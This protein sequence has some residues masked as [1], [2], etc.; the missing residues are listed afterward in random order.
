MKGLI[1]ITYK[2]PCKIIKIDKYTGKI[3]IPTLL[4]MNRS[5]HT[6]GKISRYED[7]HISL[8]G[9]GI[10]EISFNVHKYAD[11]ILC[12]VWDDLIDLKLVYVDGFGCF[13]ISV[14]Y[15]DNTETVKSIH[16][17]SLETELG[18]I[19]LHD[20]HVN[21]EEAADMVLTEYSKDNYDSDGNYIPTVFYDP[22]NE[23][24]SLLH[25]VIASKA[26]HW[27]IGYVTPYITLGED[28][29][30]EESSKFQ[31]TYSVNGESI[32]DFLTGTVSEESNVIFVFNVSRDETTGNIERTINCYSLCDCV[33]QE[34]G[35]ILCNGIGEDTMV[36][37]SKTKLANEISISSNKDN[38]KNCFCVEGGDD[39]ITNYVKAANMNGS[40]YIYQF[41][42]FQ[43][44]DMSEALKTKIQSYQEMMSSKETEEAYY[45]KGEKFQ[46]FLT[47]SYA[48]NISS[49]TDAA[50][51]LNM[52]QNEG[53][54]TSN[55]D[56]TRYDR[57]WYISKITKNGKVIRELEHS[58][59]LINNYD[60]YASG[61]V[62]R[63]LGIYTKLCN[64]YD[65]LGYFKSSM[66]PNADSATEPGDAETQY[67]KI[68]D[69]VDY[70]RTNKSTVAVSSLDDYNDEH[71]LTLTSRVDEYIQVFLDSRFDLSIIKD[72][73]SYNT[74]SHMWTGKI[75]IKQHSD[76]TN[77]YPVDITNAGL[78]TIKVNDD[79]FEYAKQK[80]YKA[81]ASSSMMD[82]DFDVANMGNA[83]MKQYF[84]RYSLNRLSAFS[85]GYDYCI[86]VLAQM[87]DSDVRKSLLS[88]YGQRLHI[89]DV[90]K[91]ERQKDVDN[92]NVMI[93]E[94]LKE[95]KTFIYGGIY[96]NGSRYKI[97]EAHDFKTYLG[98]DE[99]YKEFCS[100]TREDT[101]TNSNYVS[102]GL[103]T[104][105]CIE[106]A[107]ELLEIAN[108]EIRKACVLQRTVSTS[109]NNIFALPEFEKLYDKFSLF[110][111]IRVK[112]EDEIL[113]LR[114]IGIEFSGDSVEKIDVTFS[115]QIESIDGKLS[116]LQSII[117]QAS[118][119][120]TS[121]PSTAL[122]AK[123][124]AGADSEITNMYTNGLNAAKTMLKNNDNNEVTITKSGIVCKRMDDDGN[125]GD[126]QLRITG[127]IMALTDDGWKSVKMAVGE[128]IFYNPFSQKYELKYGIQASVIVGELM[129]SENMFIGNKDR[130][131]KITGDG[132][133][134]SNGVIKSSDYSKDG[135]GNETGSIIDLRDGSFSF[136]NGGLKYRDNDLVMKN[137][138]IQSSNAMKDIHTGEM[139]GNVVINLDT[140]YFMLGDRRLEFNALT[141]R[142]KIKGDITAESITAYDSYKLYSNGSFKEVLYGN[143]NA[144]NNGVWYIDLKLNQYAYIT[145]T[146][147]PNINAEEGR[148]VN[149]I[150]IHTDNIKLEGNAYSQT[151]QIITSDRNLKDNIKPLTDKHIKFFSLLQPVSFT[152]IDGTY[153][154][155]HIGF[156]SQDVENAMYEAGLTDLDFAGFCKD[157]KKTE[158]TDED[159]NKRY[160]TEVDENGDPIYAYYLRYDEFVAL[161][162]FIIQKLYGE[163][164][165]MK[166][167]IQELQQDN[168][169]L[170]ERLSYLENFIINKTA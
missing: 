158:I 102:D 170:N 90:I 72:S 134:I 66:M 64:A 124:G 62:L 125:Y 21:D 129:C 113:K 5:F 93:E 143:Y 73:V 56:I 159:G 156:I 148:F 144:A 130:S 11:G 87:P 162:T 122:Q 155:A 133:E 127:N 31:R 12:P 138:M 86:S 91:E 167:E 45:G 153:G 79:E 38:V 33:D 101:Y 36:L 139:R 58:S 164:Q 165:N 114:L 169:N 8:V 53:I 10:D 147:T 32:Y 65:V 6:I 104:Y 163:N 51:I 60:E 76:E 142:L 135:S 19:Y 24:H 49:L 63:Q 116:D 28:C 146:E 161:N 16:G 75:Q 145:L 95:Q 14:D 13:E 82:I 108:K 54:I 105:G 27:N 40:N 44:D 50:F 37:V 131:V 55:I 89:V 141:N 96:I 88:D 132:I 30:P 41:A 81:L 80:V 70:Y 20:F 69:N 98:S 111:Y 168:K 92:V 71:F 107:K 39:I 103:S 94:L 118:S 126:K 121:F 110:N 74:Q 119:I 97:Y 35:E 59:N 25:H 3:N 34:T 140:G 61:D 166:K 26:P 128:T 151:G 109:L 29:Q 2:K 42:D 68:F 46:K 57:Y 4:L 43:Y 137:G 47:S 115:E 157:V 160:E 154:R 48:I 85:D 84:R 67:D 18:Q 7:W 106:K 17:F 77:V 52:C 136:C 99:L 112:T 78:L 120:A 149:D 22:E 152:Y 23:P 1:E 83:Q 15:T 150:H 123:K 100:Y 9:N 117:K